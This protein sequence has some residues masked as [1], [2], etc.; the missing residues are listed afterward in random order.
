MVR[1]LRRRICGHGRALTFVGVAET[2]VAEWVEGRREQVRVAV[3]NL[4][5]WLCGDFVGSRERGS[6]SGGRLGQNMV[7]A[8]GA[9][10]W[11]VFAG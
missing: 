9:A 7:V 3:C 5:G 2:F 10:A 8:I 6:C 1:F 4:R 11:L